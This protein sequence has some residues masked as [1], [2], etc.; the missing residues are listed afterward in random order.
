MYCRGPVPSLTGWQC[1]ALAIS[2]ATTY[3]SHSISQGRRLSARQAA[4][5]RI[6]LIRGGDH[7]LASSPAPGCLSRPGFEYEPDHGFRCRVSESGRLPRQQAPSLSKGQLPLPP[8]V[9]AAAFRLRAPRR[10][11][12]PCRGLEAATLAA[13]GRSDSEPGGD[14]ESQT[15]PSRDCSLIVV[16]AVA[17]STYLCLSSLTALTAG[18]ARAR[19]APRH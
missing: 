11:S 13:P 19:D 7:S 17:P 18:A 1:L 9:A 2:L 15:P 14:S 5:G 12:S 3:H 6:R 10:P 16:A 8:L 4:Q